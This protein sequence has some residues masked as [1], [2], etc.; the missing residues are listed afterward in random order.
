MSLLLP[1]D[2]R[3]PWL[4]VVRRLQQV[5]RQ[6]NRE[7]LAVV[8]IRVLVDTQGLPVFWTE[9]KRTVLEPKRLAQHALDVLASEETAA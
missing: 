1:E 3:R 4:D 5:A 9:P 2:I 7:Q 8:S 6:G